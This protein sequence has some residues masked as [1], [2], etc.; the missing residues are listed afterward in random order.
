MRD[1]RNLIS[2]QDLQQKSYPQEPF[3]INPYVPDGGI[4][5][6]WGETSTGK[7]PLGW[8]MARC[9]A[10]GSNFFGLP[11]RVGKVLYIELDTPERLVAERLRKLS[12]WDPPLGGGCEFL[13]LPPL[14][15]PMISPSDMTKLHEAANHDPSMVIVN[16][17]RKCHSFNDK[18]PQTPK[19]VYEFF[20]RTFP[21]VALV[22]V[23]HTKKSQLNQLTGTYEPGL[24]RQSFS[25]AQNWLNDAQV[26]VQL[27]S[28]KNP[29]SGT[30][31]ILKHEKSQVSALYQS[32]SLNLEP[33]GANITC[34][35]AD[36]VMMI[37]KSGLSTDED[38]ARTLKVSISSAR[39]LRLKALDPVW[40]QRQEA[41]EEKE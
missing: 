18:E 25:G 16:T 14:S 32:L 29:K 31:L 27:K 28:F 41:D 33:D 34:P 40:L 21:G 17:L 19:M 39:R 5:F 2:W 3:L 12:Q 36:A 35:E 7:S 38:I 26:G 23:H 24:D 9:V 13:F 30:N 37:R 10:T 20:Q 1:I 6:F 8:E 15:V 11:V 22:F 4:V